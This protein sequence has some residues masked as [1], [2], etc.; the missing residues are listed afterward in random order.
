MAGWEFM[1]RSGAA[2]AAGRWR[3]SGAATLL[4]RTH[5]CETIGEGSSP[6]AHAL[7][8]IATVAPDVPPG[9]AILLFHARSMIAQHREG[10]AYARQPQSDEP[11][12]QK[13]GSGTPPGRISHPDWSR[14]VRLAKRSS[15][16]HGPTRRPNR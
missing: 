16:S 8:A 6:T 11:G 15:L 12:H 5:P 13:G 3:R 10:F 2:R 1:A 14:L 9:Q 4:A 7:P